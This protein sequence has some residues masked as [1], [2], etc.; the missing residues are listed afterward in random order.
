MKVI[1]FRKSLPITPPESFLDLSAD[2]P[3]PGPRDLLVEVRAISVNPVDAKI[4][5][6]G[7]PGKPQGELPILGWDAAGVV[8]DVGTEV[9]LFKPGDEV[10]YAGALDRPGSYAE[11]QCVDERIV[12]TKPKSAGFAAAAAL[13]LTHAEGVRSQNSESRSQKLPLV[14]TRCDGRTPEKEY[15]EQRSRLLTL[16]RSEMSPFF[17][18]RALH[19]QH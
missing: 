3:A 19:Q 17:G 14:K 18:N 10:Y 1:S 12:G 16:F 5:A 9:T 2:Q 6:G 13:P 11:F 15:F 4:R 8:R 7:G